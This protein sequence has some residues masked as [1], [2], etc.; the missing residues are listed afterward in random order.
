MWNVI[1]F[2]STKICLQ[3]AAVFMR[4]K[5][6]YKPTMHSLTGHGQQLANEHRRYNLSY[7]FE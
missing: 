4:K 6:S 5:K 7:I 2:H 3:Q 1:Y